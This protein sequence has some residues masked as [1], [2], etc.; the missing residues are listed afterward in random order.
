MG[1]ELQ[2]ARSPIITIRE[3]TRSRYVTQ[4]RG[5]DNELKLQ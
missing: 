3:F 1:L 4:L 5:L 2:A